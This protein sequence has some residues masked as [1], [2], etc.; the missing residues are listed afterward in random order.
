MAFKKLIKKHIIYLVSLVAVLYFIYIYRANF[1][2][3]IDTLSK[4][5]IEQVANIIRSWGIGAPI[6][7]ILLM[8]LQAFIAPIPAFLITGANGAV[9][10]IWFGTLIS[11]FGAMLGALGTFYLSRLFGEAFVKKFE[12]TKGLWEKV[13]EISNKQG[14]KVI[15]VGRLLPFISFDFLSYAAGL[16]NM[17]LT[18]FLVA[19]GIGMI[20]GTI[21]YVVLG[22]EMSK[23]SSYS[24]II[25]M[26]VIS[27]II[28]FIFS[29]IIKVIMKKKT[30]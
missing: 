18:P 4:G 26:I 6:L 27:A 25:T 15:I 12:S 22:N 10:G 28:I 2:N 23:L 29:Y 21:A 7:S 3:I 24:K 16:S 13:D 5:S 20:P 19:T 9:F 8:L 30:K 1:K 17:K 14:F 11:W